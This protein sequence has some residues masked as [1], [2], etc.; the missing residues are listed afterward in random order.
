MLPSLF[1]PLLLP[2]LSHDDAAYAMNTAH[3]L[4]NVAGLRAPVVLPLPYAIRYYAV[5]V[6]LLPSGRL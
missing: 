6:I 4:R 2:G 1:W 5:T 3:D